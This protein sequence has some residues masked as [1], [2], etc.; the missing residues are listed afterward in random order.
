MPC[1]LPE[2]KLVLISQTAPLRRIATLAGVFASL[3]FLSR[4]SPLLANDELDP[5][6]WSNVARVVVVPDVHGAFSDL[7]KLLLASAVID[8]SLH[9][10]GGDTH[11]VS[12]G[13]LLDRGAES[14]KVMDLL[15]RIQGEA[16]QQGGYVHVVAG[17]HEIMNLMGDLRYVSTEEYAAF[18]TPEFE[19][20]RKLAYDKFLASRSENRALSFL[21]G[22][23]P[24][25][26]RNEKTQRAFDD[27]YPLGYFGHHKAFS[28]DGRYGQ[29]LLSLPAVIVINQ[30]A[31]VHGGL[32]LMMTTAD[33]ETLNRQLSDGIKRYFTLWSELIDAGLIPK[34]STDSVPTLAHQ[35]LRIADPSSCAINE[36]EECR[37]ERS[38]ARNQQR[39]PDQETL[40]QLYEF[41]ELAD[42][43]ILG[44]NGPLWYRGTVHCKDILELPILDSALANLNASRVVVGHTPTIDRRVHK[45]R[46]DRVIMLDTGMLVSRYQGRPAALIIE[47]DD[48]RVQYLYP[49][50]RTELLVDGGNGLYP[51][52][53]GQLQEA[54]ESAALTNV[55]E[56]W[57]GRPWDVDLLYKGVALDAIFYPDSKEGS[58]NRELA[59]H[60]LD[61]LLGLGIVPLTIERSINGKRGALQ[62]MSPGVLNES[63]RRR[64]GLNVGGWCPIQPQYDLMT[65]FDLLIDN[66]GRSRG[67]Y[68][69]DSYHWLLWVSDHGKAFS[70]N[71]TLSELPTE[72]GFALLPVMVNS[73]NTLN[74][75][76]LEAAAGQWLDSKQR[77]AILLRRDALLDNWAPGR[78]QLKPWLR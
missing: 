71:S 38:N 10:I 67:N 8:D 7:K 76:N 73:L 16:V 37:R 29:W 43:S 32:P 30:T 55:E 41:V 18:S 6:R 69:Y 65:A 56:H 66:T 62:L 1:P 47:G 52:T 77:G 35:A 60:A 31:F 22:A 15:M 39:N 53:E 59:A 20:N 78:K 49:T 24:T 42:S 28:L 46:D 27:L 72:N 19:A 54:L 68:G 45:I 3:I 64:K 2:Y 11:L 12:L 14:R 61:Q 26:E 5:W 44:V 57:F 23:V 40:G 34:Q 75:Q 9:W 70:T 17:N 25:A 33:M 50:E 51:L 13:D 21:G 58:V 48:F 74:E 63:T 4:T 36:W